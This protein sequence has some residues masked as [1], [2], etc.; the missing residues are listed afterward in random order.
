MLYFL[1]PTMFLELAFGLTKAIKNICNGGDYELR[2]ERRY[3]SKTTPAVTSRHYG[4]PSQLMR[5][6][7]VPQAP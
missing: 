6:I 7:C 2:L 5:A 4:S 1:S 3:S